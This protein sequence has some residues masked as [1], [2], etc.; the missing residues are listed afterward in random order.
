MF[1]SMSWKHRLFGR[2]CLAVQVLRD[3]AWTHVRNGPVEQQVLET[4]VGQEE[5]V[6]V[7]FA[8]VQ[9]QAGHE[10]VGMC[11]DLSKTNAGGRRST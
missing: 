2:I 8:C 9:W 3:D 7:C 6:P 10:H 1:R 5:A 11:D 4:A